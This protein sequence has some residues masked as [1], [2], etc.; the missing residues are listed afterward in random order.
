MC[1]RLGKISDVLFFLSVSCTSLLL[2]FRTRAVFDRNPWIVAFFFGLWLAVATTGVLVIVGVDYT[3]LGLTKYCTNGQLKLFV[4]IT[5]IIPVI[6]DTLV[7][8]A[9]S[10]RLY[11]N[12]YARP[13][14]RNGLQVLIFG[15]YLP[16][17]SKAMLQ[18]GQAYYLLVLL[19]ATSNLCLVLSQLTGRSL[20]RTTVT[21]N[22]LAVIMLFT[23][24]DLREIFWTPNIILMNIMACRVFTNT[25]LGNFRET[26]ITTSFISREQRAE[27]TPLPL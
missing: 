22:L 26:E 27:V 6:N 24:F 14:L 7:F 19:S 9:I 13:T 16:R 2:F 17:F 4:Q 3:N 21:M 11:S 10:W 15:H 20:H 1:Y 5:T 18:D 12:S 23:H 8:L 25:I